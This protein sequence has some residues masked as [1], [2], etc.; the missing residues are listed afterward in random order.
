MCTYLTIDGSVTRNI[1]RGRV[2]RSVVV[3]GRDTFWGIYQVLEDVPSILDIPTSSVTFDDKVRNVR[4]HVDIV[5]RQSC[6]VLRDEVVALEGDQ[7]VQEGL[8][9]DGVRKMG[10]PA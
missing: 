6:H 4:G 8:E 5:V 3:R 9:A 10:T 7:N 1:P 2:V